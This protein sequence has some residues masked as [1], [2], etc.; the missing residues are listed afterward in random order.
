MNVG[1]TI[2]RLINSIAMPGAAFRTDARVQALYFHNGARDPIVPVMT[3]PAGTTVRTPG[4]VARLGLVFATAQ[5]VIS[6][7]RA[8]DYASTHE[9]A[10][11]ARLLR[12]KPS[13][14]QA[15]Q[16]PRTTA[17]SGIEPE[18]VRAQPRGAPRQS[19]AA[20]QAAGLL[21]RRNP[22]P[23]PHPL[24]QSR[25]RRPRSEA[26][27]PPPTQQSVGGARHVSSNR[28][29]FVGGAVIHGSPF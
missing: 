25:L 4:V 8:T 6:T 17:G 7:A 1:A 19:P 14:L 9:A 18:P 22:W 16:R 24:S 5:Q 26:A 21:R 12:V 10:W 20:A 3:L 11:A 23:E 15:T 28:N 27:I 2:N 13:R 29:L